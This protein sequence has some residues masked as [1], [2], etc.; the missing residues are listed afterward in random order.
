MSISHLMTVH[1]S[2]IVLPAIQ[3]IECRQAVQ[4]LSIA[5]ANQSADGSQQKQRRLYD[6][7]LLKKAHRCTP[8]TQ[9][10]VYTYCNAARLK[11]TSIFSYWIWLGVLHYF[12]HTCISVSGL[13][14][15]KDIFK[16]SQVSHAII[17]L[18]HRLLHILHQKA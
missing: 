8:N 6:S 15:Q 18:I 7:L 3:D 17:R 14:V 1:P 5:T 9:L 2:V 10:T 12:S 11:S 13:F 4:R 16:R